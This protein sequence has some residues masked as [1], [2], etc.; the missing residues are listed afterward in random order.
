MVDVGR[1]WKELPGVKLPERGIVSA[2]RPNRF[3]FCS[4]FF[5][6]VPGRRVRKLEATNADVSNPEFF[7]SSTD[8]LEKLNS[9]ILYV[10]VGKM[11]IV[12]RVKLS[13][14]RQWRISII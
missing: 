10:S 7:V 9:S 6:L 1:K 11:A 2:K 3:D 5:F 12:V 8:K 4:V 14:S 13:S